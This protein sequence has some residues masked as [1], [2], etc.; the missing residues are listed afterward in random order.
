MKPLLIALAE[1]IGWS[2]TDIDLELLLT[3]IAAKR[4][5]PPILIREWIRENRGLNKSINIRLSHLYAFSLTI[6]F[7]NV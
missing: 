7:K 3:Y 1:R 4:K 2:K 5:T 6:V